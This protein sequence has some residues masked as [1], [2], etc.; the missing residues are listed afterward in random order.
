MNICKRWIY[1]VVSR[2]FERLKTYNPGHNILK[3]FDALPKL[4]FS[5]SETKRDY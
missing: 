5:T 4:L 1:R 3:I 2:V